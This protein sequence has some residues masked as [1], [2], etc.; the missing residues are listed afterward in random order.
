MELSERNCAL[1]ESCSRST[2]STCC[3]NDADLIKKG[4]IGTVGQVKIDFFKCVKSGAR[5]HTDV[6]DNIKSV[7]MVF[8]AVKA[9]RTEKRVAVIDAPLKKLIGKK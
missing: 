4:R 9:V 3:L 5:P 2:Y 7:A 6:Y 1:I 8:A